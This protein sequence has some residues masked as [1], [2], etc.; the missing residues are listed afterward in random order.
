VAVFVGLGVCEAVMD[1][2]NVIDPD[3]VSEDV[4]VA[5]RLKVAVK[6]MLL[7]EV[8]VDEGVVVIVLLRDNE[9]EEV[10]V[11]VGDVV[12]VEVTVG[13]KSELERFP[14]KPHT[15]N[16]FGW[17]QHGSPSTPCAFG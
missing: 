11:F 8:A 7:V 17:L 1:E 3:E 16:H 4:P 14:Q 12:I 6:L 13:A 2:V 9:D 10:G 15:D 5:V